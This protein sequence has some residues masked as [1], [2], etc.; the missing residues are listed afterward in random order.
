MLLDIAVKTLWRRRLRSFLTVL[1]VATAVQLYLMMT[2]IL[3][4]YDT[5]IQ[6]QVAMF[7]G[8]IFVQRPVLSA[9]AGEDFPSMNSAIAG[10]TA[11]WILALE[12]V[13]REESS[14]VL[15]IPLLADMR[16]NMPPAYF[17]VGLEP[18]RER[19]FLGNLRAQTG[20]AVLGEARGVILGSSAARHYRPAGGDAPAAPGD[21]IRV[22]DL[23]FTV[24]GV[25]ERA[26]SL[27]SGAVILPLDTVQELF[28]RPQT[29]SAVI[30]TPFRVD[31]VEGIQDAIHDA[32]PALKASNAKDV[33]DNARAMMSM[34]RAFFNLINGSAILST[35]MV[36]MIVVLIAVMEQRRDIGTL[37][38]MGARK[39]R[40]LGMV[41]GESLLLTTAGGILALP[42]S[43]LSNQV[44]SYG[45]FYDPARMI[46]L[47]LSAL[48]V[49]LLIGILA[50]ALP[51]WQAVRVDPLA[52]MQMD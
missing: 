33:A 50:A 14:A 48:G 30:L 3:N 18:G 11:E 42:L 21:T 27:Y 13:N 8:K 43:A 41:V 4:F 25:L 44:F 35:V 12:G 24:L 16:P 45:L 6:Q 52:A 49:C 5:D 39:R 31:A 29:V 1:G 10:D 34:Q 2:A 36:V 38:A 32:H 19:A 7:A 17:V 22:L 46:G 20:R 23:E 37:R 28:H 40:I 51:A 15:F 47:W 26:S 9:G